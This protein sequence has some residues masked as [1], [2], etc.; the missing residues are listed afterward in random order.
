VNRLLGQLSHLGIRRVGLVYQDDGL[1]KD[2]LAGAQDAA[3]RFG[4]TLVVRAGYPRNTIEVGSAVDQMVAAAPEVVVLGATT[5]AA[6]EFTRRYEVAGGHAL[7]Y[8]MSI[9]DTDALLKALGTQRARGYAFSIVL[10][11]TSQPSLS[12]VREYLALQAATP[13]PD[14]S[15]RSMEGFIAAKALVMSLEKTQRITP[16]AITATLRSSPP[17]DLGGYV[18]DFGTRGRG[19]SHYVNFGIFGINGRIVQ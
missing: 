10:P 14:L 8:G 17:L 4:M 11:Q 9:I 6:I 3:G 15:A 1:G 13:S 19:G 2:V 18:L 16:E 12:I 7:L 5:A